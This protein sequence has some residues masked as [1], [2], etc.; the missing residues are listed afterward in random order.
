M[1]KEQ[2]YCVYMHTAPNGKVYV[3]QTCQKPENRWKHGKGYSNN[4]YFTRAIIKYGWE[5]F[6][7]EILA[8][9]LTLEEANILEI[10]TILKYNS[11]NKECGFNIDNGG[12]GKGKHSEET[13]KKMSDGRKGIPSKNKGVPMSEEQ[14]KLISEKNKGKP[15]PF[16]GRHHTDE[17]KKK[18]SDVQSERKKA[19]I[20]VETK[21]IY[22]SYKEAER[23]TGISGKNISKVC[24]GKMNSNGTKNLTAGGY[25]WCLLDEYDETTYI[26]QQPNFTNREKAVICIETG[27]VYNSLINAT[28]DTGIN[29]SSILRCCKGR[30]GF[31]GKLSDGTKLHWMYYEDYLKQNSEDNYGEAI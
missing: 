19:V 25:H 16:K 24:R 3:G 17:S 27:V 10:N 5:N 9:N 26:M 20:C 11:T 7:H 13:L 2:K 29:S 6:K 22:E 21:M 8:D 12:Y 23:Q 4:E 15:S 30:N 1:N 28:K 18:L 31:A 14:K